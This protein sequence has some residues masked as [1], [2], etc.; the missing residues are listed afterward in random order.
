MN[1]SQIQEAL[2]SKSVMYCDNI[3]KTS[4][5]KEEILNL[6]SGFLNDK[7]IKHLGD[8]TYYDK[9]KNLL[10]TLQQDDT[11][12]NN[13]IDNVKQ[14]NL[15]VEA[16]AFSV[17]NIKELYKNA[18]PCNEDVLI[19]KEYIEY[20]E[21]ALKTKCSFTKKDTVIKNMFCAP[22]Y[23][24]KLY[25]LVSSSITARDF[26]PYKYITKQPIKGRMVGGASR[27]GQMELEGLIANG[28]TRGTQEFLTVKSDYID[29]KPDLCYQMAKNGK[30][31]M[32]DIKIKGGTSRVV[33]ILSKFLNK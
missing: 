18:I 24:M 27:L 5:N 8:D 17:V 11:M 19:K 32:P 12:Y 21:D 22:L 1:I 4:N 28:I 23:I 33:S 6:L 31:N 14:N 3:I 15:Y 30:Y 26:G 10:N 7:I 29:G 16:P 2:I 13:F 9:I 25:K 20:M